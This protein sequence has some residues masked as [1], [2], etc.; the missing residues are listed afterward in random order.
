MPAP[1]VA[2]IILTLNEEANLPATLASLRGLDAE[3][4]VVDSGSTDRTLEIARAAGCHVIEHPFENYAL[5]RNWAFD[6]LPIGAPWT[7]CLDA[8]ERLTPDLVAEIRQTLS[9]SGPFDGYMLRKR[10]IFMGRWLKHGGQYPAYHLRLFRSGWGRCEARLYDQ[11]FVVDGRVGQ[12]KSDYVDVITSDL[13]TFVARHNRWAELE[14]EEILARAGGSARSG[15]AVTPL[16]TGTAIERRRFMRTRVYQRFPLFVRP[17]LFWFY[18]YV[19]RLG[20]LDGIE[21]LVFH[22]LQRFW[23]RF[24]IDAKI[25]E[26]KRAWS[27]IRAPWLHTR[28]LGASGLPESDH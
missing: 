23:F 27:E 18:G 6:H 15:P 17:F 16:L 12:L 26:R 9:E 7:L 14:A 8:D 28:R 24:L 25:W 20:F 5:Q 19:L 4:F 22:T 11:H 1:K 13:A 21:G 10:T 3:I 2:V